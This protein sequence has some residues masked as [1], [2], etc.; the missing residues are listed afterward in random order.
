VLIAKFYILIL[1]FPT[2]WIVP[3]SKQGKKNIAEIN[4][5]GML[6]SIAT[7]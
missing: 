2:K 5:V 1:K 4:S 3:K 7:V 6:L